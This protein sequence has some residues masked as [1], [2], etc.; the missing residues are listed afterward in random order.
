MQFN[1]LLFNCIALN[2]TQLSI[3]RA[4]VNIERRKCIF[5]LSQ[6]ADVV[7][8]Q[9]FKGFILAEWQAPAALHT[10]KSIGDEHL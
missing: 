4:L 7:S 3:P 5:L 6:L 1:D 8:E 10:L 2:K 9:L